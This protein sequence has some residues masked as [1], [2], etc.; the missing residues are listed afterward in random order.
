MLSGPVTVLSDPQ[1]TDR[2]SDLWSA[3][4]SWRHGSRSVRPVCGHSRAVSLS[5]ACCGQSH[6]I[7]PVRP[8]PSP[9]HPAAVRR[10][11]PPPAMVSAESAWPIEPAGSLRWRRRQSAEGCSAAA[12]AE[13]RPLAN[14]C[15]QR[16][17]RPAHRANQYPEPT[18]RAGHV[19]RAAGRPESH[20]TPSGDPAMCPRANSA[21]PAHRDGCV[22]G[23]AGLG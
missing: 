18:A 10:Y 21:C 2:R 4:D 5:G 23:G 22:G 15:R 9:P 20:V 13:A 3:A 12:A 1:T 11:S 14:R 19:T 6:E 16:T 17:H 8:S 7:V